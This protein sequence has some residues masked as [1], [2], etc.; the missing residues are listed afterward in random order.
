MEAVLTDTDIFIDYLRAKDKASTVLIKLMK[1]FDLF[2]SSVT[3]FE[4]FLGAKT[5]R[6]VY[7]LEM[8][9]NEMDVL[10]FDFGCGRIASDIWKGLRQKHQHAEIKDIFIASIALRNDIRLCTFNRKHFSAIP[11]LR[12]LTDI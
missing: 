5:D 1:Q 9:F 11:N 2:A 7:D 8:L 6:H 4:L 10:P 3:E 12:I